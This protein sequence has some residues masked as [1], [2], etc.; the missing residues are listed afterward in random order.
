[1]MSTSVNVIGDHKQRTNGHVRRDIQ[2]LRAVAVVA[3]IADHLFG[4]PQGG[5]VGVDIFF[6]I[7]GFIITSLLLRELDRAGRI[8]FLKFYRRRI[9][10]I[11]P[12]SSLVLVVT[13]CASYLVY[14]AG[15]AYDVLSDAIA[16]FFLVGNWRF[17]ITGTDY[18]A[19]DSPPSPLQHYWSLGVEEQ[20]YL[21]WPLVIVG[22]ILLSNRTPRRSARSVLG[23]ALAAI[24]VV[25]FT[26]G[27]IETIRNSD[28]AYFST[29]ARGWELA[30]GA[31][32][33]V[34]A[35]K[36][37]AI[38]D[39]ARRFL[40]WAGLLGIA[41]SVIGLSEN[42]NVPVPGVLLPVVSAGL[43]IVAGT[44]G[45]AGESY[46][47]T[48]PVSKYLGDI[49]FSLYLWH[50]P[51]IILLQSVFAADSIK[52]FVVA[53]ALTL[54]LSVASYHLVEDPIRHSRWLE[55]RGGLPRGRI[56]TYALGT[57]AVIA[58]IAIS[59]VVLKPSNLSDSN[60]PEANAWGD[61][62]SL[63]AALDTAVGVETWPELSPSI[64]TVMSEGAPTEDQSGC[65]KVVINDAT[66]C[67]FPSEGANLNAVVLG[68][69]TG[70]TLLPTVRGALGDD[71]N[72]RGLTMAACAPIDIDMVFEDEETADGCAQHRRESVAEINRTQPD[73]VFITTMYGYINSLASGIP[74]KEGGTEWR[75]GSESLIEQI[76]ASGAKVVIVGSPPLGK[77]FAACATK[78][79]FPSECV[80]GITPTF[81]VVAQANAE[82]AA[83]SGA[84][85]VDTRAW[86]CTESDECPS[87]VGNTPVKRDAVHTTRQFAGQ[88][89]P[90]FRTALEELDLLPRT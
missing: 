65:S 86:F 7:S 85:F 14:R 71:Y 40:S 66:S 42:A 60:A 75:A 26:W 9:K 12:L 72:V 17:A 82:A 49:S 37:R 29:F 50:F 58:A 36:L 84:L 3:V 18:W 38:P 48:N 80:G 46:L 70:I 21:F 20:F 31:L 1:M 61:Q 32:L 54:G 11:L 56:V 55:P 88:L 15:T 13:V 33:A 27:L 24:I 64:D 73:I 51:V 63:S 43:L 89:V 44:G 22:A 69:S 45:S 62:V 77:P 25:S 39:R 34:G 74:G 47:L 78:Y 19:A 81:E 35:S 16:S 76:S 30:L 8:S 52:Y 28:W 59:A 23:V 41:I 2:G 53:L 79:A 87:F 68:D 57:V 67:N 90:V 10:R 5:F 6:V 4:R 83:Q